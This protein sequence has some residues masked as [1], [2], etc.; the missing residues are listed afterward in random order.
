M[1]TE[2]MSAIPKTKDRILIANIAL[3]ANSRYRLSSKPIILMFKLSL[4]FVIANRC[5]ILK[6][7]VRDLFFPGIC[8]LL[9]LILSYIKTVCRKFYWGF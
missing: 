9:P 2:N 3:S 6:I 8:A 4:Q 7:F 5:T 1:K